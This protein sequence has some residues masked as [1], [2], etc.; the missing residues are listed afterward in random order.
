MVLPG[1]GLP[2]D[3]PAS[4]PIGGESSA[5][6]SLP[7]T[8]LREQ[9]DPA[10][11]L[12]R[13]SISESG[14]FDCPK[15][16]QSGTGGSK[17]PP[18]LKPNIG[19]SFPVFDA[20]IEA[21]YGVRNYV[22]TI[23][24]LYD[25]TEQAFAKFLPDMLHAPDP[26]R[27]AIASLNIYNKAHVYDCRTRIFNRSGL[28]DVYIRSISPRFCKTYVLKLEDGDID[29]VEGYEENIVVLMQR[30]LLIGKNRHEIMN[31]VQPVAFSYH[32][33]LRLWE[34]GSCSGHTF[35]LTIADAFKRLRGVSA[36][37]EISNLQTQGSLPHY[38]AVPLLDGFLIASRRNTNMLSGEM[39]WGGKRDRKGGRMLR[40]RE[41]KCFIWEHYFEGVD[42]QFTSFDCWIA[43]TY[44][45]ANDLSG[46][47]RSLAAQ[48]FS[49]LLEDV[50]LDHVARAREWIVRPPGP[51]D[52]D[53]HLN[54][55]DPKKVMELQREML[56]RPDPPD[57]R[58]HFIRF[59]Q[60]S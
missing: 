51:S 6:N 13:Y 11:R 8:E 16:D 33:M 40:G 52:S 55:P 29:T 26:V 18:A 34:R 7:P 46:W 19:L 12:D 39:R 2:N 28:K 56:P 48:N 5:A 20:R 41:D 9:D 21:K 27:T 53:Y 25:E 22:R 44:L 60:A 4:K 49:A 14:L 37:V 24:R 3:Q 30:E 17:L 57:E 58:V 32:A 35:H 43:V 54:W 36:L 42:K 45:G 1:L 10:A 59:P 50:D 15:L 31:G 38:I 47:E 23:A